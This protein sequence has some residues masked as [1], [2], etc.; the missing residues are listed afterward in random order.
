M[1][2]AVKSRDVLGKK[3]KALRREGL[4]P[5][6]LY[7]HGFENIH[8]ALPAKE[9]NKI[10]K[11]AGSTSVVT[12][13]LGKE[14][15]SAMIHEVARDSVTSEV[16]HVDFH[17]VR[18]DELVKADVPLE[19][20]GEALAIKASNAVINKSMSEIEV[21]AFPQDLP[22]SIVVDLSV[23][24][25]LD[26][27]IYVKDLKRPKGVTFLIDAETAV[28][29]ATEPAPEEVVAPVETVDVSAIKTE[30]EEKKAERDAGKVAKEE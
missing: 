25:A 8:L 9:F 28:A 12:L 14:S 27:T 3:V 16:I 30:G 10:L 22:H 15:K 21:E 2:L 29:T 23:L 19:F 17:Q 13:L 24:D 5:A 4:I 1:D 6:E 11:E 18:M 20:V 26:K 7:G